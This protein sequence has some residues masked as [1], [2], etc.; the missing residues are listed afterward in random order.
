MKSPQIVA[1]EAF[2]EEPSN[3][4]YLE[5]P[6]FSERM[7][8]LWRRLELGECIHIDIAAGIVGIPPLVL[9]HFI[10]Q[11]VTAGCLALAMYAPHKGTVH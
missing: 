6:E 10:A 8:H 5:S 2:I 4:E 3:L 11:F 7:D 9:G 1:F